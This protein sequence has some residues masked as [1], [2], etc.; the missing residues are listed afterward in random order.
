MR[1]IWYGC[2]DSSGNVDMKKFMSELS[3]DTMF[4]GNQAQQ[5]WGLW[6]KNG[7]IKLNKDGTWRLK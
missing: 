6:E 3:N 2:A 1:K 4:K 5:Y 7:I